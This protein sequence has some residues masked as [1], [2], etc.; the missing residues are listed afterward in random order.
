MPPST[1]LLSPLPFPA[2]ESH[3]SV[4]AKMPKANAIACTP[5]SPQPSNSANAAPKDVPDATPRVSGVASGLANKLWNA[6]P[7]TDNPAPTN[8]ASSTLGIRMLQMTMPICLSGS[9][10]VKCAV[11]TFQ[12]SAM[13]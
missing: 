2:A 4:T 3:V 9:I 10:P 5:S 12:M 13:G 7:A 1:T 8:A 6:Q 11:R